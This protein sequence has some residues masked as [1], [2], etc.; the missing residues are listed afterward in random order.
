MYVIMKA[1]L[2]EVDDAF[3]KQLAKAKWHSKAEIEALERQPLNPKGKQPEGKSL[4][5][6]L[7]KQKLLLAGK[8][9][10]I[11]PGKEGVLATST[12][13]IN[14]LPTP[15]QLRQG[16][17]GPQTIHEGV[18]PHAQVHLSADRRFVRVKFMEKS[19]ELKCGIFL[20]A[21]PS[22]L[23]FNIDLVLPET[24]SVGWS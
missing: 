10:N 21:V 20:T 16:Q 19:L 23:R 6:L 7:G 1:Q 24:K 17:K 8:A 4:F 11:D 2:Y 5:A 9:I 12:K 22:C 13:A 18:S 15:D 3:Y 14:C